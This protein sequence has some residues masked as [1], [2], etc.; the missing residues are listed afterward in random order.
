MMIGL[1]D[2]G[3]REDTEETRPSM[4]HLIFRKEGEAL[5]ARLAGEVIELSAIGDAI[6]VRAT[7]NREFD[8]AAVSAL[9]PEIAAGPAEIDIREDDASLATGR[10]RVDVAFAERGI[11]PGLLLTFVDLE[12]GVVLLREEAPHFLWPGARAWRAC[13][14]DLWRVETRFAANDGE[15]FFGLGQHQHGRFDQK[16]CVVELVQMNTEVA[17]PFLYSSRGYGFLWN[18]PGTGRV[19]LAGNQTRWVM[20]AVPQTDYVVLPA[21]TPAEALGGYTA[22]TGR[23]PVMPEW[24]MGFWQSKLRYRTQEEVLAVAREHRRRDLPLDC[25][26]I[27]FFHWPKM[28]E[29]CFDPA[30]FPDPAAMVAELREMGV[31]PMVSVW[32]TVNVNAAT[33]EE[34]AR[35]GHLVGSRRGALDGAIFYDRQPDGLNPLKFYDATSP[36]ARGFHWD[37]VRE[38]YARHGIRAFWLD[39][40][41]PEMYPMHPEN[42]RYH[43]GDGRAVTGAYPFLH[44]KGYVEHMEAEGIEGTVLLSRSAWAGSQRFPVLVWSGDVASTFPAFAAQIRAGLNM[45]MS[46]V[47]WWT[48]DIGG[49]HGGDVD[50]PAFH[51]L[52]VRWFQ[53]GCFCPVMRLH[54]FREHA[55]RDPRYGKLFSFGG[56]HN[57]V[58]SFGEDVY[59]ILG[60]YMRLRGRLK[61]YI[62]AQMRLAAETGLPPMRPL[63]V[64]FPEDEAAWDVCDAHLFGPDLLVA[65]VIEAGAA[66]RTVHL[67]AGA[68]WTDAW[69]GVA[70]DGGQVIE[71]DAPLERIPLFLRDDARLPVRAP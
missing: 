35:A 27:D 60:D 53:W 34:M 15:R 5:L 1:A 66:S 24:A 4:S 37:R 65:P 47:S 41:E 67:P 19:E 62:A 52:L 70:H 32:P 17:I 49:F 29:W 28:G 64:D 8:D 30:D 48:T 25:L 46:G 58:W 69:T 39:A 18:S 45:A 71:A 13:E 12:T 55:A 31:E 57:E 56:S 9:L 10:L 7:R 3:D 42:L 14:G 63:F 16:G 2:D 36:D 68:R 33:H 43:L 50:D 20:D 38:G 11:D 22:L 61:P 23:P 26:V 44:Q 51:E 21:S 59:A 40:C 6:R 54:G